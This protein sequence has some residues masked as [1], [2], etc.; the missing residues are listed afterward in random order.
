MAEPQLMT[1]PG[2]GW[3]HVAFAGHCNRYSCKPY[4]HPSEARRLAL[5]EAVVGAAREYTKLMARFT[6]GPDG[7]AGKFGRL[8]RTI[9]DYDAHDK[10][11]VQH[12]YK[13]EEK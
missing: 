11:S 3:V 7:E 5:A 2:D 6:D 4:E 12:I 8:C 10:G 9:H 13:P 1:F